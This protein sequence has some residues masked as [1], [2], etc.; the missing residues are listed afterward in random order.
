MFT[1][2][3]EDIGP[4]VRTHRYLPRSGYRASKELYRRVATITVAEMARRVLELKQG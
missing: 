1:S 2:P 4:L 3:R